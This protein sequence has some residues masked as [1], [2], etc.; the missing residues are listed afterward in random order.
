MRTAII[1]IIMAILI[2]I[3]VNGKVLNA[4]D[5]VNNY[6]GHKE[7]YYNKPMQNVVKKAD[8]AGLGGWYWVRQDG[9][10]MYGYF[11]ICAADYDQH[12]Y[13]SIVETSLGLG[14]VLDTGVFKEKDNSIVDI[15][16][17]W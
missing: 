14:I 2:A 13:G 6:Q 7:T 16:V 5:G 12:A 8:A 1:T 17:V 11:V 4:R 9:V 10:K 15:A 3:P